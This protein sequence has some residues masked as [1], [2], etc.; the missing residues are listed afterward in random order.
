MKDVK[1]LFVSL[2]T[3]FRDVL[4]RINTA[5]RGVA[6]V[7]DAEGALVGVVTDGDSRRAILKGLPLSAP[8]RDLLTSK[9][10]AQPITAPASMPL[11]D[12]AALMRRTGISHLPL[13]D[14]ANHVVE[15]LG[16]DDLLWQEELSLSAIVMAGGLGHRLRPLT[17]D[18]PKSMLPVG[19]VPIIQHIVEGL[20]QA[21]IRQVHIATHHQADQIQ[22]HFGGGED[23]GL[24]VQCLVEKQ[25]LG[26][27]GAVRLMPEGDSPMLVINGDILTMM[28]FRAML[29]FHR[30]H[31]AD[32]TMAVRNYDVEVPYG[33]V[34]TEG[35]RLLGV[36][37]KPVHE[38]LVN[39]GIYLLE[40]SVRRFIPADERSDMTD[41]VQ[42]LIAAGRNVICFPVWEYWRDIGLNHDYEQ[43]QDDVKSGQL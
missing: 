24:D 28:S 20:R 42:A 10:G 31:H 1:A 33:V 43:A 30:E 13:V 14:E 34:K 8:A 12:L 21:G 40:P 36:V 6:L 39:A 19:D 22:K 25:R 15:M 17:V 27:A 3:S 16:L 29:G 37:E 9:E 35:V 18:T 38:H 11:Q 4:A 2:D 23:F 5:T 32:L 26:T 41:L 7:V